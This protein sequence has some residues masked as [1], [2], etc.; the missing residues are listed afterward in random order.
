[1]ATEV[2]RYDPLL[3]LKELAHRLLIGGECFRTQRRV[4][5]R[6]RHRSGQR[7]LRLD[8]GSDSLRSR[9]RHDD[10]TFGLEL[11]LHR[12]QRRGV[13]SRQ[14]AGA[15]RGV[16]LLAGTTAADHPGVLR[17]RLRLD[18]LGE[19]AEIQQ[20]RIASVEQAG[21]RHRHA[22]HHQLGEA[23]QQAANTAAVAIE[24]DANRAASGQG[25]LGHVG[26]GSLRPEF[27]EHAHAGSMHRFDFGNEFDA[28]Q[29]VA[30][31]RFPDAGDIGRIRLAAGVG[32]DRELRHVNRA[33]VDRRRQT[34]L[35]RGNQFRVEGARDG[36]PGDTDAQGF[37][38]FRGLLDTRRRTGNDGLLRRV[39]IGDLD[40]LDAGDRRGDDV[41]FG[42]DRRHR[43]LFAGCGCIGHALAAYRRQLQE[44]GGGQRAG[45]VQRG[46]FAIAVASGGLRLQSQPVSEAGVAQRQSADRRL[47]NTGIGQRLALRGFGIGV[48][49]RRRQDGPRQQARE[50]A[51]QR[52]VGEFQRATQFIDIEGSLAAHVDVLRAL[53]WKQEAELWRSRRDITT[54]AYRLRQRL[55]I[56]S[57]AGDGG[58]QV[59]EQAGEILGD[60]CQAQGRA[61]TGLGLLG[62]RV[63]E[64]AQ[65]DIA[66]N[67]Q[68]RH[69]AAEICRQRGFVPGAEHEQFLRP[70][71]GARRR[72][73]AEVAHVLFE[74]GVEIG[75]TEAECR[76]AATTRMIRMGNPRP[77]VL[78]Q[79]NRSVRVGDDVDRLVDAVV[80]RQ[81][82]VIQRQRH[83]D[84]TGD[85]GAGLG[86]AEQGLDRA[87][88]DRLRCSTFGGQRFGDRPGFGT[89]ADRRAG[90]MR[91]G[92]AQR[93]RR[94]AGA[95][96]GAL[97][98]QLL[99]FG[100]WRGE[101]KGTA[102]AGTG[103]RLDHGIDAIACRF[104]IGESFQHDHGQAFAD[105]DA[106]CGGVESL[107]LAV[108]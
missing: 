101:T 18:Q 83:L 47:G 92:H 3:E 73:C 98:R 106:V 21:Q 50:F 48:E 53:P 103:D 61:V 36:E 35:R 5:H 59:G 94:E 57:E 85:A 51:A 30:V 15:E 88:R 78:E 24:R 55:A 27:D 46:V 86:V 34:G 20:L 31:E 13:V 90:A 56:A 11:G 72:R 42:L 39:V 37:E 17:N 102:I 52:R 44:I 91:F 28:V 9:S 60:Q 74:H 80:R 45:R 77:G 23:E 89:V 93:G 32:I 49:R 82:A 84:Q 65:A 38:R 43:T 66:A 70:A 68:C 69:E 62:Q 76:D 25:R 19:L 79:V 41:A 96:I 64:I 108:R 8:R 10:L 97:Q 54:Q 22:R 16:R 14:L 105:R 29:Q 71:R 2:L 99:A 1:M 58:F 7:R 4:D 100:T 33:G 104:G 95:G 75:A 107:R 40:A 63:G 6:R 26:A 81:A 12:G 67:P 87:D